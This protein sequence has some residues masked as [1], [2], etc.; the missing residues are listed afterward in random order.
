[1]I[2][3]R[4]IRKFDL[5]ASNIA[6]NRG[7]LDKEKFIESP[8]IEDSNE[9][10]SQAC[11][12]LNSSLSCGISNI[13]ISL[14]HA[15][16]SWK[17][18]ARTQIETDI[19]MTEVVGEKRTTGETESLFELPKK[20]KVSQAR[21][22]KKKILAEAGFQPCQ[23]QA[24]VT[25]TLAD[26]ARLDCTLSKINFDQKWVVPRVNRGG[27]LG[28]F[29]KNTVNLTV[30]DS[31]RYYIDT[32]INGNSENE[33]R[34]TGFY[35][36]PETSR[37][38]EAWNKLRTLNSRQNTPWLFAQDFNKII[39]HDEKLGGPRR[40]HDQMQL[41]RDVIDECGFMDLGFV[42][43]KFTWARH[44]DEGRSVR[45]RLDRCL[46]TNSWFHKFPR[47]RVHHLQSMS[48]DH[49]A[50]W[51]LTWWSKHN[52]GHLRR[53]LAEKKKML[54]VAEN[55][56]ILSRNNSRVRGL[57]V[58][59]NILLDREARMWCQRSRALWLS[60]GDSN[61]TFFHSKA[62]KRFRKNL[63]R[64][65][66]NARG[67]WVTKHEEMGL[68]L[69]NYYE[70]LFSSSNSSISIEVLEKILCSITEEM[71]ADLV[72][73]FSGLEVLEALNQM[74]PLKALGL[75]GMPPLFYQHFWEVMQYDVTNAVLSWLNTGT[76][77][78]P[79]NHTLI[80]LVPQVDNPELVT[81]FR[82]ISLCNVLYKIYSKVLANRL[83]KFL[84]SLI[85]EHQYAFAKD[86]LISDNI[87]VAFETLHHM[88][89]HSFG[90][91]GFM[92]LKLDM[93]K[94]YDRVE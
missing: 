82:P 56:A 37:R 87:L 52:F 34:F 54:V 48:S 62:T 36:E 80:T 88:K 93:S 84:P 13:Q 67:E 75:D 12:P 66:K 39:R 32:I 63:I 16:G 58:E 77:P 29:W 44:Y 15:E 11:A 23:K 40:N 46:A 7:C 14:M 50:L 5:V 3:I 83:K 74:A 18:I 49:S 2:L 9:L 41:F 79:I 26:E 59:I 53:E 10:L 70:E 94:A 31:H 22:T 27:G 85:T 45:I 4:K 33:W 78:D 35:G 20:R 90:R 64:G 25:E 55:E 89:N 72:G 1:M 43:S 68:E 38:F 86:R 47:T 6:E 8:S 61:T 71:N 19:V 42:G 30:V 81:E 17:R 24:S 28:L 73:N 51:E 92:A 69:L 65:I 21:T 60:K 91:H 76:L 57:K